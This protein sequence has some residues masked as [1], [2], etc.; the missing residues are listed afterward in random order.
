MQKNISG[1]SEELFLILCVLLA[2][3]YAPVPPC[4]PL[5]PEHCLVM[6]TVAGIVPLLLPKSYSTP[7]TRPHWSAC[8]TVMPA[9]TLSTTV[10]GDDQQ[11]AP[12]TNTTT[13]SCILKAVCHEPHCH[14]LIVPSMHVF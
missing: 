9:V 8:C 6:P 7:T 2:M 1:S 14:I 4:M 13:H 12:E 5:W 10:T 11:G 3:S